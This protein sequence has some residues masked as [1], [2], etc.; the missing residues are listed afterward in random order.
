MGW[1][2]RD[3][4]AAGAGAALPAIETPVVHVVGPGTL[5]LD[6]GRLV[7]CDAAGVRLATILVAGTA[8]VVIHGP[9]SASGECLEAL[10]EAGAA[11]AFLSMS[12]DRLLARVTPE[13][14]GRVMGRLL[15][16]RALD[17]EAGR[18]GIAIGI[19]REKI[20]AAIGAARHYQRQGKAVSGEILA[21]LAA[22][23]ERCEAAVDI[24]QLMGIEGAAAAVWFRLLG[25]LLKAPWEFPSRS[26][27]PPRDAVN[28]LLSLGS[29]LLYQR[30]GAAIE[31]T[32]L[33]PGLGAL[34]AY[35]AGRMSLACDLMEP[36][37][38]PAVDRWVLRLC[39]GGWLTP[40]D[41][42]A[43]ADGGVR[44]DERVL[45]RVLVDWER[46][47]AEGH[48]NRIV[49]DRVAALQKTLRELAG[50]PLRALREAQAVG[51]DELS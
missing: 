49:F 29:T 2:R 37:R 21:T 22:L 39:H 33:E 44:L 35:R 1:F 5:S 47:W 24:P 36:L 11:V 43:S 19:L 27:R 16:M 50:P 3:R 13:G 15:Q 8:L 31:A 32:G 25:Q 30:V 41:F 17:D 51:I 40:A 34:H 20:R 12:G 28:A 23:E 38:V 9:V 18:R 26:R 46:H 4:T 42:V 45:P 10:R 48:W 14:D 6:N 7:H